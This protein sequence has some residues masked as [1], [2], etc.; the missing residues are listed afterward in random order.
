MN[1]L[2]YLFSNKAKRLLFKNKQNLFRY[3][4]KSI[5]SNGPIFIMDF[6]PYELLEPHSSSTE[7]TESNGST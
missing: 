6:K 2:N 3:L 1:I 7:T 4:P 5:V